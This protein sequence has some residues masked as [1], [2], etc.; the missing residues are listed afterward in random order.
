MPRRNG[1]GTGAALVP[2]T[3]VPSLSTAGAAPGP[4]GALP[5]DGHD[6]DHGERP[7]LRGPAQ[8]GNSWAVS[9]RLLSQQ[10]SQICVP[11]PLL[12]SG[13]PVSE[14]LGRVHPFVAG[15]GVAR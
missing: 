9:E 15:V 14:I 4:R 13:R 12:I 2:Q 10:R 1:S 7:A 5:A 11:P 3:T 8:L 6:G